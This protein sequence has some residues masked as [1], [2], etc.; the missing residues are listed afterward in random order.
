M[1]NCHCGLGELRSVFKPST[2]RLWIMVVISLGLVV[3]VLLG[4]LLSLDSFTFLFTRTSG[5]TLISSSGPLVCLGVSLLCLAIFSSFLIGDFRKWSA[6]RNTQ[7]RIY[8][9]GFT[10]ESNGHLESFRWDEIKDINYKVIEIHS[11][12]AAPTK[13]RVIRSIVKSNGTVINLAETL[14]LIKITKLMTNAAK[15]RG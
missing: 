10:Y 2:I 1:Q 3:A 12:H 13:V 7:L 11:K 14:D 4:V 15:G 5:G 9:E 6:T 8:Q